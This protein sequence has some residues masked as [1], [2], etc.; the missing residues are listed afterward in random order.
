MLDNEF[1]QLIHFYADSARIDFET[2]VDWKLSQHL[3]KVHFPV[4]VHTDEATYDI[5]FGNLTRKFH[6]NTSWDEARFESCAHKFADMS[7]GNYGVSL[8]NDC[9]YGYSAINGNLSITLFKAGTE[10]NETADLEV[11]SFTYSL[12]PHQG[13]WKDADVYKESFNVNVPLKAVKSGEKGAEFSFASVDKKNVVLETIKKAEDGDGIIVRLY[14][15]E[16]SRTKAELSFANAVKS[17]EETNLIEEKVSGSDVTA[18]G[19]KVSFEI[20]PYEIKT[21]RVRF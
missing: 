7:E 11:H 19:N 14:E 3:C 17:V 4:D 13:T 6:Q 2:V 15:V 1:T 8:M 9:K 18:A 10:P 5:Q 21:Y 12:L 20:K 16:N